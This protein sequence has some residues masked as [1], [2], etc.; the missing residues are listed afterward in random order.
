M[1][2]HLCVWVWVCRKSARH[3]KVRT[4]VNYVTEYDNCSLVTGTGVTVMQI[5]ARRIADAFVW[6]QLLCSLSLGLGTI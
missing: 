2:L 6:F 5:Y 1:K 3:F 4:P